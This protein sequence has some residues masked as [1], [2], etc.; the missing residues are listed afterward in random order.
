MN[1]GDASKTNDTW[2]R[3]SFKISDDKALLIGVN[4]ATSIRD[5]FHSNRTHYKVFFWHAKVCFRS[6]CLLLFP[7]TNI[8]PHALAQMYIRTRT[9]TCTPAAVNILNSFTSDMGWVKS[10][11]IARPVRHHW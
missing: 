7:Y 5:F 6:I 2:R 3:P 9:H 8:R 1:A 4:M 11:H 10:N